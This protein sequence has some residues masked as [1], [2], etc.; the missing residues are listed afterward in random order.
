MFNRIG[1]EKRPCRR[2]GFSIRDKSLSHSM[3]TEPRG[4]IVAI[5]D[6]YPID[7]DRLKRWTRKTSCVRR[8]NCVVSARAPVIAGCR[9]SPTR[10]G[11][12]SPWVPWMP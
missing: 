7:P 8:G 2:E 9:D 4:R 10:R 11:H 6:G 5:S 1:R 3:K 12:G